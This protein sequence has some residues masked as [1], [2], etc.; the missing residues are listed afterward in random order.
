MQLVWRPLAPREF[1]HELVWLCVSLGGLV[2]AATWM[3]LGLPWPVCTFHALTGHPCL[4]CGATRSAIAFFH[5]DLLGALQ[6]N[7]LVFAVYVAITIFD[8]YAFVVVVLRRPRLRVV[9]VTSSGKNF[10]RG[11]VIAAAA[12]NWGYLLLNSRWF[13]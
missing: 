9:G 8:V 5:A 2:A 13:G 4:T 11:L 3:K 7:P 10:A 1:D 12:I 6:W